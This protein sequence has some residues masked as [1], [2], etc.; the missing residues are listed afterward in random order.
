MKLGTK[1][2]YCCDE[3]PRHK[4]PPGGRVCSG[5]QFQSHSGEGTAAEA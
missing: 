3:R 4:P 5:S 2:A 1:L